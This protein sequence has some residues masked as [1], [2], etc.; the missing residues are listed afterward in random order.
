MI[1]SLKEKSLY[2]TE[3]LK[4]MFQENCLL[5]SRLLYY[6][7]RYNAEAIGH[8]DLID[9]HI[10]LRELSVGVRTPLSARTDRYLVETAVY[11]IPLKLQS[12]IE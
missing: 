3:D 10:M 1:A 8:A 9:V 6:L 5:I 7:V 2:N 11:L 12:T 4:I